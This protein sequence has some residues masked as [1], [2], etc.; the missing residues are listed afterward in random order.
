MKKSQ[1]IGI[2]GLVIVIIGSFLPGL[3]GNFLGTVNFFKIKNIG[4]NI[5]TLIIELGLDKSITV[6]QD[7]FGDAYFFI[8]IAVLSGVFFGL[9]Y[10]K[11]ALG[12][13]ILNLGTIGFSLYKLWE[14]QQELEKKIEEL[15]RSNPFAQYFKGFIENTIDSYEIKWGW[16]LLFTGAVIA[17]FAAIWRK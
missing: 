9:K 6:F 13:S 11:L 17:I 2:I 5:H 15:T 3:H 10:Y 7:P 12:F 16:Y 8:G 1:I 4:S 14:L